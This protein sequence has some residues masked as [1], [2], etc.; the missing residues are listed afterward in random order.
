MR[1]PVVS[2]P[3]TVAGD[4]ALDLVNGVAKAPFSHGLF[5]HPDIFV[6]V[7]G[8]VCAW[9]RWLSGT[10][11]R[12]AN[13]MLSGML[14]ARCVCVAVC[15]IA[16][17]LYSGCKRVPS[18]HVFVPQALSAIEAGQRRNQRAQTKE[19]KVE[20]GE[21]CER[22]CQNWLE[23]QFIVPISY[24]DQTETM[25]ELV[26]EIIEV[27]HASNRDGCIES[28]KKAS[29]QDR[30]HCIARAPSILDIDDCRL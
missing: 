12:S 29:D 3:L 19:R 18:E 5:E 9:S 2:H 13:H 16:S 23:H 11:L 30:A 28:C 20:L 17:T 14:R 15:F 25:Q 26:D 21:L 22:A 4:S 24:D 6:P 1:C 10:M 7:S 27:Q 8:P